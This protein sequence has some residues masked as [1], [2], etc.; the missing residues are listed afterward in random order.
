[1]QKHA[2]KNY[3]NNKKLQSQVFLSEELPELRVLC[4]VSSAAWNNQRI[5]LLECKMSP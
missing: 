2:L 4:A 3:K 5:F 1:M